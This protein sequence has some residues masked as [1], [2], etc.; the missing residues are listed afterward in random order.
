MVITTDSGSRDTNKNAN[1]VLRVKRPVDAGLL[2]QAIG[3]RVDE[4]V[5]VLCNFIDPLRE[6]FGDE[7]LRR[8][9]QGGLDIV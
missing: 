2:R 6:S 8:P 9:G 4:V 7:V 1:Q 5:G 3:E